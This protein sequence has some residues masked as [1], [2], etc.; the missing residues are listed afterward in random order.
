ML[1]WAPFFF[2]LLPVTHLEWVVAPS[3]TPARIHWISLTYLSLLVVAVS[4]NVWAQWVLYLKYTAFLYFIFLPF[5][6]RNCFMS[7]G[8]LSLLIPHILLINSG[9]SCCHRYECSFVLRNK[10]CFKGLSEA[11]LDTKLLSEQAGCSKSLCFWSSAQKWNYWVVLR[12]WFTDE[13]T[14]VSQSA[15]FFLKCRKQ[16]THC[17][18]L[19]ESDRIKLIYQEA[20]YYLFCWDI[21]QLSVHTYLL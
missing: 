15:I 6:L 5:K 12:L 8:D 21:L 18:L 1:T 7:E 2:L 4:V 11:R 13:L 14:S 16:C 10:S 19:F 3:S 20:Y 17:T 9:L